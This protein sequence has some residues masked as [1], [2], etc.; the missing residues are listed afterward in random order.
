MSMYLCFVQR[1]VSYN[2]YRTVERRRGH[3][4]INNKKE[5]WRLR[6]EQ[7]RRTR[8]D[9]ERERERERQNCVHGLP[10]GHG[11]GGVPNQS[12]KDSLFGSQHIATTYRTADV[13]AAFG[14]AQHTA[15]S[16]RKAE[17]RQDKARQNKTAE[18]GRVLTFSIEW[19]IVAIF[20]E[21]S[22]QIALLSFRKE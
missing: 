5:Q 21:C 4:F 13:A 17:T 1:I 14:P 8:Q 7:D 3:C 15:Q 19:T 10:H 12:G 9:P 22:F 20:W 6:L 16:L 2:V 11:H 18:Q